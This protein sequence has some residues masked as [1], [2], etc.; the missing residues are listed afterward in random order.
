[1]VEGAEKTDSLDG[2]Y[3]LKNFQYFSSYYH[4]LVNLK[5]QKIKVAQMV[6]TARKIF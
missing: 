1:M 6:P 2:T 3:K 4:L 5:G